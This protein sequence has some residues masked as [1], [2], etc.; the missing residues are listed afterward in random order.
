MAN[1]KHDQQREE[2]HA[3]QN[4]LADV[5][6]LVSDAIKQRDFAA[7]DCGFDVY[8]ELLDE[9]RALM[10]G[11][12]V[13]DRPDA[14]S[15]REPALLGPWAYFSLCPSCR[16]TGTPELWSRTAPQIRIDYSCRSCQRSWQV[17]GTESVTRSVRVIPHASAP[18][19][20][21]LSDP[22]T[23]EEPRD[24]I[25]VGGAIVAGIVLGGGVLLRL[26]PMAMHLVW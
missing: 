12:P 8:R 7:M 20:E 11:E 19:A 3:L 22:Q 24:W 2:L 6:D 9:Q 18:L 4:R 1:L 14:V 25:A 23:P 17:T 10:T 26:I 16:R 5:R 15:P 21:L 13:P